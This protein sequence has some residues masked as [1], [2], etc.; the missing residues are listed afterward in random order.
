MPVSQPV[1]D[2]SQH[3]ASDAVGPHLLHQPGEGDLVKGLG[4]VQ[5]DDVHWLSFV[6]GLR[7]LVHERDEV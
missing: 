5:E 4:E 1:L 3:V 2:P 6:Q 7:Y